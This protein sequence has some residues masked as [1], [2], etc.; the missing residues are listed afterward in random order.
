M[1]EPGQSFIPANAKAYHLPH[2]QPAQNLQSHQH[3]LQQHAAQFTGYDSTFRHSDWRTQREYELQH[4][5]TKPYDNTHFTL[6]DPGLLTRTSSQNT[7]INFDEHSQQSTLPNPVAVSAAFHPPIS[8]S[9]WP[10][11]L[12]SHMNWA[13]A[14]NAPSNGGPMII[15]GYDLNDAGRRRSV[16]SLYSSPTSAARSA[17]DLGVSYP[18]YMNNTNVR[19][20]GVPAASTM[21]GRPVE[22]NNA[23]FALAAAIAESI[24]N[25][26][27]ARNGTAARTQGATSLETTEQSAH[28]RRG[29]WASQ[30]Q[31]SKRRSTKLAVGV[32]N[33]SRSSPES[34]DEQCDIGSIKLL[35]PGTQASTALPNGR[36]ACPVPGCTRTFAR[37]HNIKSHLIC[38]TDYRPYK[39][40]V[41]EMS[42]R[43]S[44][45][46][47]RHVQATHS[48]DR[49]FTCDQCKKSFSRKDHYRRHVNKEVCVPMRVTLPL[50]SDNTPPPN[51]TTPSLSSLPLPEPITANSANAIS[52]GGISPQ[53]FNVSAPTSLD[54][55]V[56]SPSSF[57]YFN[58]TPQAQH[59]S[60]APLRAFD[61]MPYSYDPY[62]GLPQPP[63]QQRE[64]FY[65][66][67]QIQN[68]RQDFVPVNANS[69][70]Q[71]PQY[72]M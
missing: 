62:A 71:Q 35:S 68:A 50:P 40:E 44:H 9:G 54:S 42:F 65:S 14:D 17:C 38:H 64:Q 45:D 55:T 21:S 5:L 37:Y 60:I 32:S 4:P 7:L 34:N 58:T 31:T 49:P 30:T 23:N 24:F 13:S 20:L 48:T 39:C 15:T 28:P 3:T 52:H 18:V 8:T 67:A 1:N 69:S 61:V 12:D 59:Q 70:S 16:S 11:L 51:K 72:R 47:R 2:L 53:Q 41:C 56:A 33:E 46:L 43:R 36:H 25:P 57:D 63:E 66:Q 27:E 26:E 10:G 19:D 6:P 22:H 29:S